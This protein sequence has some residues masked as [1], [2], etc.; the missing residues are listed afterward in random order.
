MHEPAISPANLRA[1]L[2]SRLQY[3]GAQYTVIEIM[4]TP[5]ALILEA[6]HPSTKIQTDVNGNARREMRELVTVRVYSADQT[7]LHNEFIH[8]SLL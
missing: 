2:G 4:D 7:Q 5:S 8:I 3:H 6:D 1:M